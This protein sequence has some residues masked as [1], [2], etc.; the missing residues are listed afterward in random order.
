MV[1]KSSSATTFA[2]PSDREVSM[3]RVFAAPRHAVFEAWTKPE[4][5]SRWW[6]WRSSTMAVCE[7]DLR[8]GGAYRFVTREANGMM[9]AFRGVYQEI[10]AP[11]RLAYTEIFED[12]PDSVSVTTTVFEESGGKTTMTSTTI[13]ESQDVRD[14]VIQSG[15]EAGA[16]ESMDRLAELLQILA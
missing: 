6:G 5:V 11:E 4:H 9:V 2:T 16:S 1:E 8:V 7:I 3:T 14:M 13:Y 10:V 15:M 12:Y